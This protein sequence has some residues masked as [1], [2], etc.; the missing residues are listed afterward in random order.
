MAALALAGALQQNA[1]AQLSTRWAKEV[2]PSNALPAYPR[3]QLVRQGWTNLNGQWDYAITPKNSDAPAKY[4]GKIL[5]PYPLESALSG[6]QKPLMP[7]QW[8][9]YKRTFIK[10]VVK[11]GERVMLHFGAVDFEATVFVNDVE[12]GQHTGGYQHFSFDITDALQAGNNTLQLRVWDPSD[13][14]ANPH[15]KQVLMPRDIMYTASSGIWQTVWLETVPAVSVASI[16]ITPDIDKGEIGLSVILNGDADGCTIEAVAKSNSVTAGKANGNAATRLRVPVKNPRLWSPD[17]PFLYDLLITVKKN[18][19]TID[20]VSSYCGL[21]KVEIKNDRIFVNNRYLY[22]LGTLDQGF[23]P[24][25][26]YTAPT[27]AALKFDIEAVKAMGFNMIRKHIKIEPDRWYYWADKLGMLVWQDMV[28]PGDLANGGMPQFEK[29]CEENIAQL[30]NF[31]CIT[32]WVLFNE[33]WNHYDQER[34]TRWLKKLDPTRLVNGHS[35]EMLFVNNALRSP[36]PNAWVASDMNDVHAY[37]MP[38]NAPAEPGKAQVLGEFGG[39]GV[40]V[41]GHIWDELVAG[42][43]YDGVVT[44]LTMKQQ[45]TSMVDS[46]VMLEKNGLSAS[47]YTQPYDVESEQNGFLTYDR[48]IIKLPVAAIRQI[49]ERLLPATKNYVA[50]TKGFSAATADSSSLQQQLDIKLAKFRK[51]DRDPVFLRRMLLLS[52]RMKDTVYDREIFAAFIRHMEDPFRPDNLR[53]ITELTKSTRDSGFAFYNANRKRLNEILGPNAAENKIRMTIYG[54]DIHPVLPNDQA[55][56][57]WDSLEK[58][59][60]GKYGDL[61]E[62]I[63]LSARYLHALNNTEWAVAA[64]YIE[65]Q[66]KKFPEGLTADLLNDYAWAMFEHVADTAVLQ[67]ALQWSEISLKDQQ[68]KHIAGFY[69]TY[70]NLLYRLGRKEEAIPMAQKAVVLNPNESAFSET[71]TKMMKDEKTW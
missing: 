33:K 10:P 24:D 60:I 2:S 27:D 68:N 8:L 4:D 22:N 59:I 11:S 45:Y 39:I 21:R 17:D 19:K 48:E 38:R 50:A 66:R 26:L 16:K 57:D 1:K 18:G 40:P 41:E 62:E 9:W 28:N 34:L 36:S 15:G 13:R 49:N 32:T 20:Q 67:T 56:P 65:R 70:A 64:H 23:W 63:W 30:Y 31:P 52:K 37:P 58:N 12:V 71:L 3:P 25:G 51:G 14:G 7:D 43:G 61:G 35:G 42:W 47:V 6:V 5:V 29:E 46:L 44:P 53:Y 69:D 55:R 54:S